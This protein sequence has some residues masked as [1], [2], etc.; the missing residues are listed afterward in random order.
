MKSTAAAWLRNRDP[1]AHFDFARPDRQS[2]PHLCKDC[3]DRAVAAEAQ[4]E[5]DER[6]HREQERLRQETVEQA[7]VQE[8]GG[9]FSR[10]H[11]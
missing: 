11:T 2:Y 1:Q 7:A 5:A 6:E 9:W 3:Q 8:A 4:A 10:F